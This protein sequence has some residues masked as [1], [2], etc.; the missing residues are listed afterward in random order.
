MATVQAVTLLVCK[1]H[2]GFTVWLLTQEDR[3]RYGRATSMEEVSALARCCERP[4]NGDRA[5]AACLRGMCPKPERT[6][7]E[8]VSRRFR[9]WEIV[10]K[11]NNLHFSTHPTEGWQPLEERP[12][13][14]GARP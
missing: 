8:T 11:E 1:A 3:Y 2:E 9:L 5:R 14:T 7:L 10:P 12:W 4:S 6:R 13:H